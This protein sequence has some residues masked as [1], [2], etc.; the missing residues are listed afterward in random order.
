MNKKRK[1]LGKKGIVSEYLPWILISLAILAVLMI[2]IFLL[3][4]KGLSIID[5]LKGLFRGG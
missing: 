4:G 5:G 3:K 2:S 1:L